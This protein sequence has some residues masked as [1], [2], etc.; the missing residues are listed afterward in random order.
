MAEEV[1]LKCRDTSNKEEII[2]Q[3][4]ITSQMQQYNIFFASEFM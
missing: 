2:L 1:V 3:G 4:A